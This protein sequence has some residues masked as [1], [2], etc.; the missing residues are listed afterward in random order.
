MHAGK[1]KIRGYQYTVLAF[2]MNRNET[3]LTLSYFTNFSPIS[4]AQSVPR[5]LLCSDTGEL[6]KYLRL[7][8]N[9]GEFNELIYNF[10][11]SPWLPMKIY[12]PVYNK[13][14]FLIAWKIKYFILFLPLIY[15]SLQNES[16]NLNKNMCIK[17]A[18]RKCKCI[19]TNYCDEGKGRI[20]LLGQW[21]FLCLS[22]IY[23]PWREF[24]STEN[25]WI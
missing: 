17:L 25:I 19:C 23:L 3:R 16:N 24:N 18:I 20:L 10:T 21:C 22:G 7:S 1:M 15:Y 4:H 2:E 11:K 9:I 8:I 5:V 14:D 13:I 12:Y 6:W